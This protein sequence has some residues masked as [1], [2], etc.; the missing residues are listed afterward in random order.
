M[1]MHMEDILTG[2]GPIGEKQVEAIADNGTAA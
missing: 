2:H 1:Q